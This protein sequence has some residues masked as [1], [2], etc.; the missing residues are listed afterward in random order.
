MVLTPGVQ[1]KPTEVEGRQNGASSYP[2][3][4]PASSVEAFAQPNSQESNNPWLLEGILEEMPFFCQRVK[5]LLIDFVCLSDG[6]RK[7]QEPKV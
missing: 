4:K 5:G 7:T 2:L 6:L 3:G 1:S